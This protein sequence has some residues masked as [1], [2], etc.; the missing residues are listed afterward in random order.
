MSRDVREMILGALED[1]GG[2]EYLARQARENPVAFMGLLKGIVPREV[3]ADVKADL[4]IRDKRVIIDAT[5]E[6][7]LQP[8][9]VSRNEHG[10]P[11]LNLPE[12]STSEA[13]MNRPDNAA[14][15]V[16]NAGTAL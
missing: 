12:R 2:Q 9:A 14:P 15:P 5:V 10:V 7:L 8:G 1:A 3:V 13:R 4:E 6:M 11:M 16:L